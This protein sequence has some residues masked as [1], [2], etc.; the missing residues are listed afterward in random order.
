M[1]T[2]W[3]DTTIGDW[4]FVT[5]DWKEQLGKEVRGN[6]VRNEGPSP[7]AVVLLKEFGTVASDECRGA[8][9][10]AEM[11]RIPPHPRCFRMSCKQRSCRIRN[12]E[13]GTEDGRRSGSHIGSEAPRGVEE[14]TWKKKEKSFWLE[15]GTPCFL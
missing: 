2:G 15:G 10:S 13:E 11:G 1:F 9:M 8:T 3:N 12:L 4:R 5:G 14:S 6:E 7:T